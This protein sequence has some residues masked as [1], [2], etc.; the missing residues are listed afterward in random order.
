MDIKYAILGF[1]SWQPFT[2]YDLKKMI[3]GSI[4]FYW[5]GN[6]NQIYTTLVKLHR[7]GLVTLEVQHQESL[8]SRKIY[9]LTKEGNNALHEW[10]LSAPEFPQF[11]K[12]FLVQLAWAAQL[13]RAD[14]DGLLAR[15][16][17]EVNM[18]LLM[19]KEKERRGVNLNPARTALEQ[20]IWRMIPE[21]YVRSYTAELTWVQEL[22]QGIA[23]TR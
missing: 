8:P 18:Q 7:E 4:A 5:S 14:L 6:N 9:T 3:A 13:E 19:L 12:T 23:Q 20:Y 10:V 2:G 16:E 11:K 15:Y 21:N 22:R 1:L 17:Y